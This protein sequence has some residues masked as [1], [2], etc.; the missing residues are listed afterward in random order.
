M[1]ETANLL[2]ESL[3][4]YKAEQSPGLAAPRSEPAK[5]L[6]PID[7]SQ[8]YWGAIDVEKLIE[9]DHPAR[10]IWAMVTSGTEQSESAVVD[11]VVDLR[12]Q[13]RHQF[14][15]RVVSDVRLRTGLSVADGHGRRELP[16]AV[17]FSGG[18]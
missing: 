3:E 11:G 5:R 15:A 10:G 9:E 2:G 12:L 1:S 14:G 7:R 4:T 6:K 16:H 17:G 13:R 8:V 18:A